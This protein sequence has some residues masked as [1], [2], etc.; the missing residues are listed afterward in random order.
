MQIARN[1]KYYCRKYKTPARRSA[2]DRLFA[3]HARVFFIEFKAT[4]EIAT[5]LQREEHRK[6]R[7][8]GLTVYVVDSKE[9]FLKV[10]VPE[11]EAINWMD[12]PSDEDMG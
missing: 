7:K 12:L 9:G 5:D 8:A 6:M 11:D 2:P 10:F 4:G 3:K 1:L